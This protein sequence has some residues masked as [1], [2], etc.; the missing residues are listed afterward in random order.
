[1]TRVAAMYRR[2]VIGGERVR[3]DLHLLAGLSGAD[4]RLAAFAAGNEVGRDD[5]QRRL[6][7]THG[8]Q[9]HGA[10]RRASASRAFPS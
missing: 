5:I 10:H 3:E 6:R 1:M 8:I 4:E 7:A 9:Q 2:D